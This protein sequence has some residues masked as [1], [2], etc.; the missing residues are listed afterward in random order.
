VVRKI[1]FGFALLFIWVVASGYIPSF[2][3]REGTDRIQ[4]G[5]FRLSVIDDVTHGVTAL[6]ALVASLAS[7]RLSLLFL[8][9]FGFYYAL[10]AIFYLTYGLF[11]DK[12]LVPNVLLNTPHVLISTAMLGIVYYLY[13]RWQ[14]AGKE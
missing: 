8:T 5:L 13:P 9:A 14:A 10:D 4:F 7:L 1:T 12:G 6:A 2:I 11:N 3:T